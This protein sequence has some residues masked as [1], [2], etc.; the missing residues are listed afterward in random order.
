MRNGQHAF[1]RDLRE[2]YRQDLFCSALRDEPM[3]F[4]ARAT[5]PQRVPC[6]ALFERERLTRS[7]DQYLIRCRCVG[8][9]TRSDE[10]A[11][12]EL[13]VRDGGRELLD[14]E[15]IVDEIDGA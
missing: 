5:H 10:N 12:R 14:G 8:M 11:V 9:T 3:S 4:T 2:R 15:R 6:A 7:D 1:I 13:A